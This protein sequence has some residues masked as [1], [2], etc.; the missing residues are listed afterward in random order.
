VK[1]LPFSNG[2]RLLRYVVRTVALLAAPGPDAPPNV[3][4]RG[5]SELSAGEQASSS[6]LESV[7]DNFSQIDEA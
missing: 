4:S 6:E 2:M 5:E 3:K 7:W 1:S